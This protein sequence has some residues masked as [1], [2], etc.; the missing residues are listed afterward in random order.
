LTAEVSAELERL[1]GA[2]ERLGSVA[3]AYS[4]G[5]DS[6]L[7]VKAAHDVLG[8]RAVAV[9]ARSETYLASEFEAAVELAR[10]IGVRHEVIE[11]SE[12]GVEGFSGNP[13]DR[14]YYCKRELFTRIREVADRLGF[15]HVAD[16]ANADDPL[17]HRPGLRAASEL[18]V[19]SPLA[20]AGLSK[21]Q[22]REVSKEL[23]LVT[24]SKPALA[25]L[26]SRFPYG[27]EITAAKLDR[28]AEAEEYLRGLGL[29]ELRVRSHGPVARIEVPAAQIERLAEAGTRGGIVERLKALGFTYVAIDLEG[30]RSGS[31]NETLPRSP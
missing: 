1:R 28:V 18:G 23:G 29:E 2:V 7:V 6:T 8:G 31:M 9:T 21:A 25:C 14:C 19:V 20:E 11:T 10:A 5:V 4:G 30:L 3:V 12:L 22:V 27:E 24:W 17:D 15:A 26:A 16:G 13:P